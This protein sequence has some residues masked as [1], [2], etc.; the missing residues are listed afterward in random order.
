MAAPIP[1]DPRLQRDL[2]DVAARAEADQRA[3]ME[4]QRDQA[5]R[6]QAVAFAVQAWPHLAHAAKGPGDFRRLTEEIHGFLTAETETKD[7]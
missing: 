2:E 1:T 7:E 3:A 4:R 6:M 5:L